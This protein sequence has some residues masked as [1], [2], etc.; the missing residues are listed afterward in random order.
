MQSRNAKI[1]GTGC[2]L[3]GKI[4][5]SHQLDE[6]LGREIGT[7]EKKSG[8]IRRYF[9]ENETIVEMAVKSAEMALTKARISK[10][11]IDLIIFASVSRDKLIPNTAALVQKALGLEESGI[12]GIDI[13]SVCLS[14]VTALDMVSYLVHTGSYKSILIIS[15]EIASI[16]LDWADLDTCTLFGDG[17]A[18]AIVSQSIEEEGSKILGSHMETYT[19]GIDYAALCMPSVFGDEEFVFR[20]KGKKSFRLVLEKID[21]FLKTLFNKSGVIWNDIDLVIPHQASQAG[22]RLLQRRLDVPDEKWMNI[23]AT[24]ANQ[25][26]VSIPTVLHRAIEEGKIKRGNKVLLIGSAAGIALGGIVLEY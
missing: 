15:S 21:S 4:V 3:P 7:V 14:F 22:L 2:Y 18:A 19:Q 17:A 1:L 25:I 5:Y 12:P 11:S 23:F 13:Q 16:G 6:R 20:M 26:S 10:N 8:V 24:H 9:V